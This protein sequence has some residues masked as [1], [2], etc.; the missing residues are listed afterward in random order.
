MDMHYAV[1][2]ASWHQ[3]GDREILPSI[4]KDALCKNIKGI[5]QFKLNLSETWKIQGTQVN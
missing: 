4:Y 2:K 5:D 3:Y 1:S